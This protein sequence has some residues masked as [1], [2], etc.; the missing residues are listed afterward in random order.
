MTDQTQNSCRGF[1]VLPFYGLLTLS[2]SV[3]VE[4]CFGFYE[5]AVRVNISMIFPDI[6]STIQLYSCNGRFDLRLSD[7]RWLFDPRF[8]FDPRLLL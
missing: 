8:L 4:T 1:F 2:G 6:N 3:K 5:S 7:T